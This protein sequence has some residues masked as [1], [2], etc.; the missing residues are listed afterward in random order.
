MIIVAAQFGKRHRGR[1]VLRALEVFS[2]YEYGLGAFEV[3][4]MILTH[5]ER[6]ATEEDVGTDCCGD[7]VS[8]KPDDYHRNAPCF[9]YRSGKLQFDIM[10]SGGAGTTYGMCGAVSAFMPED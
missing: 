2:P 10:P 7:E 4:S 1:S 6:F 8:L 9:T 5:P 3:G